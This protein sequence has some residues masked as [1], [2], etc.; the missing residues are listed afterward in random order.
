MSILRKHWIKLIYLP[1]AMFS[2]SGSIHEASDMAIKGVFV[3]GYIFL[4]LDLVTME[5]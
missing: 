4:V 2:L 5:S 1:I 3:I